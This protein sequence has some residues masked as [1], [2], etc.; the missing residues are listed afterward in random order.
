MMARPPRRH[1][2]L[3]AFL[4]GLAAVVALVGALALV[5]LLPE[6]A[7]PVEVRPGTQTV[8]FAEFG[9][10]RDDVYVAPATAPSERTLIGTI[11]HAEGWGINPGV[12][13]AGDLFAYT[14]LPPE[15]E[16]RRDSPAELWLFDTVSQ[17]RTRLA[18]DADL[19][20]QPVF[21][22]DGS[23]LLYRRSGTDQQEIVRVDL[24]RLTRS[25]IHAE[26]TLFGIFPIGFDDDGDLLFA[27]L[28]PTG[29]D[30]LSVRRGE[31]PAL[32]FHASDFI[33]RDWRMSP[34]GGALAYL[35]PEQQGERVVHRVHVMALS[36]VT[37]RP[38][39]LAAEASEQYGPAWSP[40][41]AITMGQEAL[42]DAA[43]ALVVDPADAVSTLAPAP[44]GFDVPL[45]WS[46]DGRYL[47]V[48]WFDG[49]NSAHPGNERII[50]IDRLGGRAPILADREVIYIGWQARA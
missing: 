31:A 7:A 16:G 50:V 45:A 17:D 12:E 36:S 20:I 10:T 2:G 46:Q 9:R 27:R 48:R 47:A 8:V 25:V 14:V 41:G 4:V 39:P 35:A 1:P 28:S 11:E 3:V 13:M 37:E 42:A 29:T 22:E 24:A 38:L 21:V 32:L 43:P 19:L 49:A 15:S 5:R 44:R 30:V 23:E 26:R 33:A 34:D 40:E 6:A 18:R